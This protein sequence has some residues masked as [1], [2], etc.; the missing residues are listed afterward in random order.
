MFKFRLKHEVLG[1]REFSWMSL[2]QID[3]LRM[4]LGCNCVYF[5]EIIYKF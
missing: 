5:Y 3:V 1:Q 4:S 2:S